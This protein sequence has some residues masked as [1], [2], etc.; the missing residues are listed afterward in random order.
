MPKPPQTQHKLTALIGLLSGII[1]VAGALI[2]L[3]FLAGNMQSDLASHG[4]R[5]DIQRADIDQLQRDVG[6]LKIDM[7]GLKSDMSWV[8]VNI[9]KMID[10]QLRHYKVSSDNRRILMKDKEI[11]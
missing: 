10:L 5:L 9:D 6:G 7:Q 2:A 4:K 8:R 11:K 1:G 3:P